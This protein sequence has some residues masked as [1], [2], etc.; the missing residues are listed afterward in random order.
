M[1][2]DIKNEVQAASREFAAAN[3]SRAALDSFGAKTRAILAYYPEALQL[4]ETSI[5]DKPEIWDE[6]HKHAVSKQN[7]ENTNI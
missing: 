7:D 1:P 2:K 5:L 6:I 4:I 3:Y